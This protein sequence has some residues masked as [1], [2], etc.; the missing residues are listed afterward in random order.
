MLSFAHSSAVLTFLGGIAG[1]G[2]GGGGG[3]FGDALEV[4]VGV[5]LLDGAVVFF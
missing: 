1:G 4:E 5:G 2:G 3:G